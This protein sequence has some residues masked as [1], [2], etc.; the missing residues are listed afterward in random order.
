VISATIEQAITSLP[1][2]TEAGVV[3]IPDAQQGQVPFT[4]VTLSTPDHPHSAIPDQTLINGI[5]KRVREQ[6]GGIATLGVII[7]GKGMIP[8]IPPVGQDA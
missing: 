3:G 6:I 1:I 7:Q 5:Q 8:K 4:F 2:V